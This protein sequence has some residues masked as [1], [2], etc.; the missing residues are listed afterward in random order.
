MRTQHLPWTTGGTRPWFR[1][2]PLPDNHGKCDSRWGVSNKFQ[3]LA[4]L[5]YWLPEMFNSLLVSIYIDDSVTAWDPPPE[6]S[7]DFQI[8]TLSQF[9][10]QIC[11][12]SNVQE[13]C[14]M[15]SPLSRFT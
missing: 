12:P 3:R 9:G 7:F 11:S 2:L 10:L 13:F 5:F 4:V 15:T 14:R 6:T 1:T 8:A